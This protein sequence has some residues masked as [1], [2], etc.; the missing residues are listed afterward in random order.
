MMG[1]SKKKKTAKNWFTSVK[2]AFKSSAPISSSPSSKDYSLANKI[3]EEGHEIP[4]IVSLE[5]YPVC[6]TSS[7]TTTIDE[8]NVE[9]VVEMRDEDRRRSNHA[10]AMAVVAAEAAVLAA[11]EAT[12]VSRFSSYNRRRFYG[13]SKEERAATKIQ[14]HYKGYLA[15]RALRALRGLVKLQALVRG[16]NV[17]KQ[18]EMTMRCMQAIVRV[19][20]RTK[21]DRLRLQGATSRDNEK[22]KGKKRATETWN[23]S[24]GRQQQARNS[25]SFENEYASQ[26]INKQE[27][28]LSSNSMTIQNE[29]ALAYAYPYQDSV[30]NRQ[31]SVDSYSDEKT[32]QGGWNL[33]DRWID[34]QPWHRDKHVAAIPESSYTSRTYNTD[35]DNASER[36]ADT[37]LVSLSPSY[38]LRFN[39]ISNLSKL[40]INS[41]GSVPIRQRKQRVMV[42]VETENVNTPSYMA[43]TQ[44]AKAKAKSAQNSLLS[45]SSSTRRIFLNDLSMSS[46]TDGIGTGEVRTMNQLGPIN[47]PSPTSSQKMMRLLKMGKPIKGVR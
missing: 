46:S 6:D 32:N 11:H 23:N 13:Y 42:S 18:A 24:R 44:S 19:Q 26:K 8:N 4:E 28:Y 36:T 35:D 2:N 27:H 47:S 31:N 40:G 37:D 39:P 9:A 1:M 7:L 30:S 21:A 33:L 14:S 10:I 17:R 5:H 16:H 38:Q 3:I 29:R 43:T 25:F 12:K 20:A 34:S 15:R 22:N 45:S 41:A